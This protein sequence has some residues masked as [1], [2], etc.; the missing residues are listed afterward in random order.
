MKKIFQV[1]IS[2]V[3]GSLP[4]L[5][6]S[7][8]GGFLF[9]F[10]IIWILTVSGREITRSLFQS[11]T[12]FVLIFSFFLMGVCGLFFTLNLK[13]GFGNIESMIP[14]LVFPLVIFSS[15]KTLDH[16][17]ISFAMVSFVVGV[18]TLNLASLAFISY[19]L[20]DSVNLQSNI[21]LANNAIVQI[22]PVFLSLYISFC[23]FFVLEQY[24]PL[25]IENRRKLGWTL[26][27]I[28]ILL[29]YLIWINSRTG[30][31]SFL[32]GATFY[33]FYRFKS[34]QRIV[35]LCFTLIFLIVVFVVP[36][37]NERFLKAPLK[38]LKQRSQ[39]T[40]SD[41]NVYTLTARKQILECS[42]EILKGPEFFYGYGTGDSRDEIRKCYQSN[43]YD[44]PLK[45]SL[46]SHN[47]YFG[48]IHKHGILGL[49][50]FL[51]LLIVPFRYALKFKSP[52][53]AVFIVL[54]SVTAMFENVFSSQKGITFYA[55]FCPLLML[56]AKGNSE[57]NVI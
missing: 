41:P 52:L 28:V 6:P 50:I 55:L 25:K 53:L 22:H 26:F 42:I 21:I 19:D 31:L 27:A 8:H 14:I 18:I 3:Y 34:K 49:T 56:F 37:S 20:W 47:E 17:T 35:S 7:W 45:R 2:L 15:E 39:T 54:F 9:L 13:Q 24:F 46:D 44:Y 23:I 51:G 36:F 16:K 57:E 29:T 43:G 32:M 1:V 38:A 4:L 40:P 11:R 30:I 48:Q 12:L 5:V 10:G 33:S